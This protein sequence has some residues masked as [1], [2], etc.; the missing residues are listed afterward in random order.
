MNTKKI[1]LLVLVLS[2]SLFSANNTWAGIILSGDSAQLQMCLV[3]TSVFSVSGASNVVLHLHAYNTELDIDEDVTITNS[4]SYNLLGDDINIAA[5]KTVT[6]TYNLFE[7][8]AK[9]GAGT[10]SDGSSTTLWSANPQ[11][12]NAVNDNF[13][14]KGNSDAKNAGTD[15]CSTIADGSGDAY[16]LAGKQVCKSSATYRAWKNGVEIGGYGLLSSGDDF[17]LLYLLRRQ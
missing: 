8:A 10:Y 14:L 5:T 9:A 13:S 17:I 12:Q 15:I 4:I 7:D 11:F 1:A 3:D 16:D 6:G 2:L